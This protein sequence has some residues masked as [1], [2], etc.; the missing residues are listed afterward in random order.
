MY[1]N[2]IT[3]A[4]LVGAGMSLALVGCG[5]KPEENKLNNLHRLQWKIHPKLNWRLFRNWF[6]VTVLKLRRLTLIKPKVF[7]SLT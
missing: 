5:E 1:K 2:K 4:I 3:R 6:V 7:Q